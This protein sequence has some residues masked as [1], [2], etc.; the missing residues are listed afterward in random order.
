M[1]RTP[2]RLAG[3][4]GCSDGRTTP[5]HDF[6][7]GMCAIEDLARFAPSFSSSFILPNAFATSIPAYYSTD[8]LPPH[9]P[10]L[11]LPTALELS[12][13]ATYISYSLQLAVFLYL[14]L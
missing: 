3:L 2:R 13:H 14:Y 5:N 4:D 6:H 11:E 9:L 8:P 12:L 7:K 10:T 1:T